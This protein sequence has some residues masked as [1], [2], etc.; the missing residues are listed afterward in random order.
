MTPPTPPQPSQYALVIGLRQGSKRLLA[1]RDGDVTHQVRG[2]DVIVTFGD[3]TITIDRDNVSF[4]GQN[5]WLFDEGSEARGQGA[6]FNEA[7]PLL[8]VEKPKKRRGG[9]PPE[10]R[11]G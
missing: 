10:N 2:Q 6:P 7:V 8:T 11:I 4:I 9:G 3:A 1:W 5:L